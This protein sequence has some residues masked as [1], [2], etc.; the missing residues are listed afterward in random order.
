[1]AG[2][3]T[4]VEFEFM[5][6]QLINDCVSIFKQGGKLLQSLENNEVYANIGGHFRH[7]FDFIDCLTAGI[8]AGKIDYNKRERNLLVETDLATAIAKIDEIIQKLQAI[9]LQD[10]N[11]NIMVRHERAKDISDENSWCRSSLAREVEFLQSHTVHH[12]AI[13]GLKLSALN[14]RVDE[15]FGVTDSTLKYRTQNSIGFS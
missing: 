14:I 9:E 5:K 2:C 4:I 1:M 7:C 3:N 15:N 13:I 11:Q 6:N 8:I 10:F 12:Y